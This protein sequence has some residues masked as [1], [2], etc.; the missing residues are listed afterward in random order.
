MKRY[1]PDDG[2]RQVKEGEEAFALLLF[3]ICLQLMSVAMCYGKT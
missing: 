1:V 2:A 3:S